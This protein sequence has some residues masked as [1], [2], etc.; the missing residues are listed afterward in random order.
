[1]VD[2]VEAALPCSTFF[3]IMFSWAPNS[4]HGHTPARPIA[5][6][7]SELNG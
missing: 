7:G 3:M 2:E 5:V 1:M 4:G 6:V